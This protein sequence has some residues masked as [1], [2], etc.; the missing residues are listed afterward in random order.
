MFTDYFKGVPLNSNQLPEVRRKSFKHNTRTVWLRALLIFLVV[1]VVIAIFEHISIGL[2]LVCL[3][4]AAVVIAVISFRDCFKIWKAY[5]EF[6]KKYQ[7]NQRTPDH[8]EA[9]NQVFKQV[10]DKAAVEDP[11]IYAKA[12][13]QEIWNILLT[14]LKEPDGRINA[15]NVLLWASGL[16][17]IAC[18]AS[19]WEKSKLTGT[20]AQFVVVETINGRKFYMGDALNKPLLESQYSIWSLA[21]G[22]Y[23]KLLPY[24]PLPNLEELVVNCTNMI[25]NEEYRIWGEVNP[26]TMVPE[27]ITVWKSLERKIKHSCSNPDDWSLMFGLVLQ[28]AL[29]MSYKVVPE[30]KNCLEMAMENALFT[31]KLDMKD[32]L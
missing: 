19:V 3:V 1:A 5:K 26:Y 7:N 32:L 13:A 18:Q 27:Y 23:R 2:Y 28:K 25:G 31:A 22:I 20:T 17:G 24:K 6:E 12:G 16:S 21:A 4:A 14:A 30:D 11:L 8:K 29:E 15:N 10:L 9:I